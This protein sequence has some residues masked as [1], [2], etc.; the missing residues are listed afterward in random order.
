M[1]H[2]F[3]T[4]REIVTKNGNEK[5]RKD[6]REKAQENIRFGY[7]ELESSADTVDKF[8][9]FEDIQL[10]SNEVTEYSSSKFRGK[11][12]HRFFSELFELM[13][14]EDGGDVLVFVHGFNTDLEGAG[15]NIE[16]LHEQ[17]VKNNYS[18]VKHIVI[19]TWPGMAPLVPLHY[20]EDGKDADRSGDELLRAVRMLLQFFREFFYPGD[21]ENPPQ[22][23]DRKIHLMAHSMGNRVLRSMM[24][25]LK[26][27]DI[28][29]DSLFGEMLLMAA[30]I[31]D[32]DLQPARKMENIGEIAERVH[33]YYNTSDNVLD[34][35]KYTKR[36]KNQLGRY[37]A[38]KLG[39]LDSNIHEVDVTR[40]RDQENW[41]SRALDH[42][43]YYQSDSVVKDVIAVLRGEEIAPDVTTDQTFRKVKDDRSYQLRKQR[44]PG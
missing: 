16:T 42:W 24:K 26:E 9:L 34:M 7:Y 22:P 40:I 23:C 27:E 29:M 4:N 14:G 28:E 13:S 18:P 41:Q 37:G 43:Y 15:K 39:A 17:Y 1:K 19:F 12:S 32:Y 2:F 38:K 8:T 3:I 31:E 6:G 33:I 21:T 25:H 20:R 11:G 35:A 30:N 5:V 36:F 44:N 10:Q